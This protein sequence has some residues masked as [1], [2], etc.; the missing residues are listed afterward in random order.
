MILKF[1]TQ[2]FA[3]DIS[4]GYF[5]IPARAGKTDQKRYLQKIA[6]F[7]RA[8]AGWSFGASA[9]KYQEGFF[10]PPFPASISPSSLFL[11]SNNPTTTGFFEEIGE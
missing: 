9:Q 10:A 8:S 4:I 7:T 3:S 11:A 2:G 6:L 5:L 1:A